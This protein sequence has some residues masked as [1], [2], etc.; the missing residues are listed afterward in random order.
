MF[1]AQYTA[2]MSDQHNNYA[3]LRRTTQ[4][5]LLYIRTTTVS[6]LVALRDQYVCDKIDSVA[7]RATHHDRVAKQMLTAR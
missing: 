2:V 1:V 7:L 6:V 3:A 5:R 4:K